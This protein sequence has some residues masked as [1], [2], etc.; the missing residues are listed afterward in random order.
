M[1]GDALKLKNPCIDL[2][3]PKPNDYI[4][5][6]PTDEEF[7]LLRNA[8][9]G[10][11]DEPIVLL[12]AWCSLR[13]GEIFALEDI[14]ILDDGIL[15]DEN[16][17]ISE[18]ESENEDYD[19]PKYIYVDKKPKSKH[20]KRLIVAPDELLDMLKAIA[21]AKKDGTSKIISI[22][23]IK[24]ANKEE[25]HGIKL[26][27][28]R[29]DS[30][31]KRFAKI[32]EY[33]NE[34]FDIRKK[35]GQEA[36]ENY[37]KFHGGNSIRKQIKL[38]DKKLP[39]IRFHDLRHYHTTVLYEAGFPDR[40]IAERIGDHIK[41]MKYIYQHLRLEKKKELDQEVKTLFSTRNKNKQKESRDW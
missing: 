41:T 9:K 15:V 40:Y 11:F 16:Y 24:E 37:L 18:V 26:F 36:L 12:A 31:S 22:D 23:D 13:E 5:R 39:N 7:E 10:M 8:I 25:K 17:A 34:M 3:P 19:G 27:D 32:I 21:K 2:N 14:D 1:F 30:Y 29:L 33:H 28:M 38:Q 6:V 35:F 4:P 20:G